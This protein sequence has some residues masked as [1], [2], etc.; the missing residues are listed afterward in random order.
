MTKNDICCNTCKDGIDA[1]VIQAIIDCNDNWSS[2]ITIDTPLS[3][4]AVD[5]MSFVKIVVAIEDKFGLRFDDDKLSIS[6]F[7]TVQS[8]IEY[9]KQSKLP[10]S[11][12]QMKNDIAD[13]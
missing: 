11:N 6:E 4:I 8:L 5:S 13:S 7:P 12:L 3:D 10:D 2:V 1:Q 9:I